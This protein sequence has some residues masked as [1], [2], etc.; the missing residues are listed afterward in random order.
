MANLTSREQEKPEKED[1]DMLHAW[2]QVAMIASLTEQRFRD[3]GS[4]CDYKSI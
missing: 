2:N 3:I 1:P 4:W